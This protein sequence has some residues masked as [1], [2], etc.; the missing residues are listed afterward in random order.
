MQVTHRFSLHARRFFILLG[1][2]A[3]G[4]II[5]IIIFVY[6]HIEAVFLHKGAKLFGKVCIKVQTA[7]QR[8]IRGNQLRAIAA[9]GW[10]S[11]VQL[12]QVRQHAVHGATT[13]GN[14]AD[15]ALRAAAQH[16]HRIRGQLTVVIEQG[17]VHIGH[18]RI[19]QQGKRSFTG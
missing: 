16:I 7:H 8:Q 9:N 19:D 15:T 6:L 12:L 3:F 14:D 11:G 18:D 5:E 10:A 4:S 2:F 13:G 17:I 1:R